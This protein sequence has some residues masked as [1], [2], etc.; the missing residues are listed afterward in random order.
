[1]KIAIAGLGY[2]GL[3]NAIVLARQHEV[4]AVDVC[5][6]RVAALNAG[7]TPVE[8]T[9]ARAHLATGTLRL[10]AT[11]D[12]AAAY[13]DAEYVFIAT[14][15]DYDPA[16]N[17]FDT[18]SIE[19]VIAQV[20]AVNDR[21]V[22]VIKST[23]PVGYTKG[24]RARFG[25]DRIVFSPE[26]LREGRALEDNL[27]P[28][29]IVVGEVSARGEAVADL[30]RGAALADVVPVLLTD[31][32]EA[33]AIKLFAN[34][35]LYSRVAAFNEADT[36]AM[37]LDL[38]AGEIIDALC[39]DPRIGA[40]YNNPSFGYGGYCLPKDS[41]QLRANF[42]DVPQ[43]LISATLASNDARKRAV[44]DSIAARGA[45]KVG[46][47]RLVMKQGSDN[48]RA[49]AMQDIIAL[50][51]ERGV[52]LVVHEPEWQGAECLGQPL[53]PDFDRFADG[54]DLIVANRMVA[55]LAPHA[56]KV[57]TRD[58]YGQD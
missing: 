54:C 10:R 40:I 43:A 37:D 33:E 56:A 16:T 18:T 42:D 13:A 1:M 11:T 3:S 49:S 35:Y 4:T 36:L 8:D 48:F 26:F 32:T 58:I 30:L 57:F 17:A 2:V 12:A 38:D 34:T 29:R 15:T 6:E 27:H 31:P 52:D 55:E 23:V 53:E 24:V 22:M 45:A 21:A 41:K 25:C 46:I 19:A 7:R 9:L 14:P 39:L 50:L 47:Y 5:V 20:L 28:T 51:H 44:A